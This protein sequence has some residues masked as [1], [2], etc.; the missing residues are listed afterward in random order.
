MH[1]H[2]QCDEE[3]SIFQSL[4]LYAEGMF[5]YY[6]SAVF[7]FASYSAVLLAFKIQL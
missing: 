2:I 6:I 4:V 5:G 1:M 3:L 7:L